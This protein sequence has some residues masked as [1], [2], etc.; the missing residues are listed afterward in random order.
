MRALSISPAPEVRMRS[1]LSLCL[2]AALIVALLYMP[3]ISRAVC[4]NVELSPE[5]LEQIKE[6]VQSSLPSDW[7]VADASEGMSVWASV[8]ELKDR[9]TGYAVSLLGPNY[10]AQVEVKGE[11]RVETVTRTRAATLYFVHTPDGLSRTQLSDDWKKGQ[12]AIRARMNSPVQMPLSITPP[13][14]P[15]GWNNQ[16]LLVCAGDDCKGVVERAA[17]KFGIN[18]R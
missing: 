7:K 14:E 8:A 17:K 13:S 15:Y 4:P 10:T 18:K 12:Q 11:H 6:K 5:E 3:S 16:Y 9:Y 2:G 1:I